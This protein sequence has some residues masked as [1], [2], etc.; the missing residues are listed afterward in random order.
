MILEGG[1][2]KMQSGLGYIKHDPV[3]L[4]Q[5]IERDLIFE[6]VTLVSYNETIKQ[7]KYRKYEKPLFVFWSN[8]VYWSKN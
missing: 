8:Y 1:P 3:W 7:E 5:C 2:M 4:L 6:M